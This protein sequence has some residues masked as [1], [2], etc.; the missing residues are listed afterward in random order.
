MVRISW[1]ACHTLKMGIIKGYYFSD[2]HFEDSYNQAINQKK[3]KQFDK[4]YKGALNQ[5]HLMSLQKALHL[6][7]QSFS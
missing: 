4:T 7:H 1:Y 2:K 3:K 6:I 5:K